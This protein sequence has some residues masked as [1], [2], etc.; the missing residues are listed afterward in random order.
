VQGHA[1]PANET[2]GVSDSLKKSSAPRRKAAER[3][4]T[5]LRAERA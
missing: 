4:P 1:E 3:C 2:K 5:V